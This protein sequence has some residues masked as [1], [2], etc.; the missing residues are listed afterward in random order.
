MLVGHPFDTVKVRLQVQSVDKPL[1]RGTYHCFQSIVRQESVSTGL[2][3]R[4]VYTDHKD[5]GK[6]L[7]INLRKY[8]DRPVG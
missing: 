7:R 2:M 1:Y 6:K 5:L 4:L 8:N 3:T